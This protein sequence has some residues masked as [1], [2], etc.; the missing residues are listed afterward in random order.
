MSLARAAVTVGSFT[1]L[2]RLTGFVRDMMIAAILGAGAMADAFFV[3]FKLANFLRRLLGEGAFNAGFVPLLA[4]AIEEDGHEAGRRFAADAF[5]VMTTVLLLVVLIAEL[6]MPSVIR[7]LAPGFAPDSE[8]YV[9][10]VALT[11]ITFPYILFICLVALLCGVLNTLGRFAAA[12][13]VQV[14]LNIV[15]I[16]A[17]LLSWIHPGGPAFALAWGVALAGI[18]QLAWVL[19]AARRAGMP[20]RLVRPRLTPRIRRLFTLILPGVI[21]AG[22][23][24]LNLLVDTWFASTLPE[25][26]PSYLFYADRLNQ[27]PLGVVGVALGTAL[28]PLLARQLRAGQL[29]QARHS[30]SRGLEMALLL[31]LPAAVALV[32]AATPI[33]RALF[34]R[35]AFDAADTAATAGALAAFASGLPAYVLIKVLAPAFFARE[36]TRSPVLV[37]ILCVVANI[38]LIVVLIGPLAHVGIAL[39]TA[40]ANWLNAILLAGLLWRTRHLGVDRRFLD[41]APRLV[42]AAAVM[43]GAL[44]AVGHAA[45]SLAPLPLLALLVAAGAAAYGAAVLLLGG[46]QLGELRA[47]VARRT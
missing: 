2:S 45:G 23:A 42:G 33:V 16:A 7:L 18:V 19:V 34:E 47:L 21:G 32:V 41:R 9:A 39:A 20:I 29:D 44:W 35:G 31:T 25:G 40:I 1:L 46:A 17:L 14:I 38:A 10:A 28:L 27:L 13:A 26:A 43:G 37:G 24:Q 4:R 6:T 11:R 15:L 5:A 36:D 22:V 3:S 30:F 12:A 8:R